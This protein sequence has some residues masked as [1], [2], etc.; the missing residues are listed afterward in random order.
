MNKL[1]VLCF[2]SFFAVLTPTNADD[3]PTLR[4]VF[5]ERYAAM[6]S[7]MAD[8]DVN[9]LSRLLAPDFISTDVAGRTENA[10]EMISRV[11]SS[12]FDPR[13]TGQT[14]I[15]SIKLKGTAVFVEQSYDMKTTRTAADGSLLNVELITVSEDTWIKSKG[16]WL[17]QSTATNKADYL[18]NG[19]VAAHQIRQR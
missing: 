1:V 6:K 15:H 13:R 17:C 14:T 11:K 12:A 16:A 18:V 9:A 7:A 4:R 5:E 10:K 2:I 3:D 19:R 8:R